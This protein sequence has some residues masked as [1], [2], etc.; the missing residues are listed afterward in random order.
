MGL[1]V[2]DIKKLL[3]VGHVRSLMQRADF[4]S[5]CEEFIS[6]SLLKRV[7][8]K[9]LWNFIN[10][11]RSISK[12]FIISP[13]G[14]YCKEKNSICIYLT[15]QQVDKIMRIKKKLILK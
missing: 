5:G 9:Y 13:I 15:S 8:R 11:R 7:L 6:H 10:N 4:I 3:V 12:K 14:K 2:S 1:V